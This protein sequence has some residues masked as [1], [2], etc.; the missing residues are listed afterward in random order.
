[1]KFPENAR[2]MTS[3]QRWEIIQALKKR[4]PNTNPASSARAS[5]KQL[6]AWAQ[7]YL[8]GAA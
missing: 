3:S 7:A 6:L 8:G 2:A 5:K 4:F 1:M